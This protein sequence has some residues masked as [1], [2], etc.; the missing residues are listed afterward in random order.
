MLQV[1]GDQ[2]LKSI[3]T[4]SDLFFVDHHWFRTFFNQYNGITMNDIKPILAE[5][6]LDASLSDLGESLVILYMLSL[7]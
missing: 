6:F 1:L 3:I 7:P 2:A 4:S 5:I